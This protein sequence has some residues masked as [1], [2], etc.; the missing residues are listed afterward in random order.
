MASIILIII[1]IQIVCIAVVVLI[2]WVVLEKRLHSLAIKDFTYYAPPE[3]EPRPSALRIVTHKA[4]SPAY[5]Q[6]IQKIASKKFGAGIQPVFEVD[7]GL[8]GGI[9]IKI[10]KNVYDYSLRDRLKR[11]GF[12]K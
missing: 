8:L 4:I 9:I 12:I 7:K 6:E 2:L 11:S 10:D 5:Q 1:A 3:G